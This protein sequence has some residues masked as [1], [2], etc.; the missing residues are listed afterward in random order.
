MIIKRWPLRVHQSCT[1]GHESG[2]STKLRVRITPAD[3]C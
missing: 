1:A 2:W 3:D